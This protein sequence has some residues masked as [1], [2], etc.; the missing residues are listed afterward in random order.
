MEGSMEDEGFISDDLIED[1]AR[2]Y[3]GRY[4]YNS[5]ALLRERAEIAHNA[6]ELLL[7]QVWNDIA[8]AAERMTGLYQL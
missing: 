1:T 2:E 7:A 3:V 6:G 5:V 8:E 4:G